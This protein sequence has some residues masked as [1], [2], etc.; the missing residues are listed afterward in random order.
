[1]KTRLA[2]FLLV[3]VAA[4]G[5]D[6]NE[7]APIALMCES[8]DEN[9]HCVLADGLGSCECNDGYEGDGT[10]CELFFDESRAAC[11]VMEAEH[12]GY[13][14]IARNVALCGSQYTPADINTACNTGWHVCRKS[15]WLERYPIDRP[16]P[17]DD[18]TADTLGQYTSWGEPQVYRCGGSVWVCNAPSDML[19]CEDQ[20]CYYPGDLSNNADGP[21]YLPQNDG[22]FLVDDDG[23]TVL[24]GLNAEGQQDCCSW[25]VDW[26][27]TSLTDSFAVYCCRD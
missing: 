25:D 16:Y 4:C 14:N 6:K 24:H 10:S 20:L 15:E 26:A 21:D 19:V 23:T 7:L 12:P 8:C 2:L 1:M 5:K 11:A 18:E 9:A 17:M 22:K 13:T 27:V 3:V